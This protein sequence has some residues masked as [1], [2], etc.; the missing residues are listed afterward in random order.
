MNDWWFNVNLATDADGLISL[1]MAAIFT[2]SVYAMYLPS[3]Q[4]NGL[5]KYVAF[6]LITAVFMSLANSTWLL[7]TDIQGNPLI[8]P[9]I[10]LRSIFRLLNLVAIVLF[11]YRVSHETDN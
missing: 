2:I 1:V 6:I 7:I 3:V 5:R 8:A 10:W 9:V 4:V 11:A